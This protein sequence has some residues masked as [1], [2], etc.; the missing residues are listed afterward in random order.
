MFCLWWLLASQLLKC[1]AF[2]FLMVGLQ[3]CIKETNSLMEYDGN[4]NLFCHT[5]Q[6]N[7]WIQENGFLGQDLYILVKLRF[8]KAGNKKIWPHFICIH[9]YKVIQFPQEHVHQ[10][11]TYKM[12]FRS[13]IQIVKTRLPGPPKFCLIGISFYCT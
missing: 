6:R 4:M 2:V 9:E 10:F 7:G 13:T 12:F 3:M 5:L 8:M 1:A 11:F